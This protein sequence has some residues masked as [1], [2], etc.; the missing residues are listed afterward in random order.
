MDNPTYWTESRKEILAWL[1]RNAPSLAELYEGAVLILYQHSLPGRTRFIGHAVREIRNRL[2][3]AVSGATRRQR[4]DYTNR[5]AAISDAWRAGPHEP[6][7]PSDAE[8]L[9]SSSVNSPELIGINPQ[10]HR[11]I[12]DLVADHTKV[13]ETRAEAANRFFEQ[14]AP[15]NKE[16]RVTM[17]PVIRNW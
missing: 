2:P 12:N 11:L 17:M 15:E 16:L 14:C 3:D 6:L 5:V 4:L 1:K 8:F 13:P 9:S 7:I 10:V